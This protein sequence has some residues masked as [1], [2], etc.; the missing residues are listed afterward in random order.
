M[1]FEVLMTEGYCLISKLAAM[2]TGWLCLRSFAF[3]AHQ[4][5]F[6]SREA[7]LVVT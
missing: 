6:I 1:A 7:Y 2:D 4:L 5:S 3:Q